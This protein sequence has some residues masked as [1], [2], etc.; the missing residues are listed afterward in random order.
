[1][2]E[3]GFV[4]SSLDLKIL[5]LFLLRRL[6]GEIGTDSLLNLCQ[7]DGVVNYFDF[8]FCMEE[9]RENGQILIEDGYCEITERGK[10]TAE[11]LE[12]SL[13]YSVRQHAE[14]AAYREAEAMARQQNITARHST[15]GGNCMVEL[16]L[17][18]GISEIL[19]LNILCADEKKTKKIER[20]FRRNAE[21][22]YQKIMSILSE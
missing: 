11:A 20:K 22:S 3:V 19:H 7:K 10:A 15:E 8:T 18:D 17:H 13:P 5:I 16:G 21:A 2:D 4:F 12:T 14:K 6:P 1:M 9:L